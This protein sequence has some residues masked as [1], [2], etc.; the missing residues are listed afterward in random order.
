MDK[1][2]RD[3]AVQWLRVAAMAMLPVVF[4]AFTTIPYSLGGH[5]GELSAR[6]ADTNAHMS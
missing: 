1:A 3:F 5:P 4:A 6:A 2:L